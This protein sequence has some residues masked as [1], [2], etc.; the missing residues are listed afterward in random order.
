MLE[1]RSVLATLKSSL[2]HRG[3]FGTFRR[4]AA[5]P[6]YRFRDWQFD[7]KH[8]VRTAG[9]IAPED[10]DIDDIHKQSAVQYQPVRLHA[11]RRIMTMLAID[12]QEFTF[13]DFGCGKGRA[14]L[15]ASE[16]PFRRILGVE[17]S[18]ALCQAA[19]ENIRA[20]T[21]PTQQC[22]RLEVAC[23]DAAQYRVP[24]EPAVLFFYNPFDAQIMS[25]VLHNLEESLREAPRPLYLVLYNPVLDGLVKKT[26]W[27]RVYRATGQF[28]IYESVPWGAPKRRAEVSQSAIDPVT[29][30]S[31]QGQR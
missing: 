7:R 28:S 17:L 19:R 21:S 4:I 22:K 16:F 10:L 6:L 18:P 27:L 24:R 2:L 15:L 8:N 29:D 23:A 13:V 1:I 9:F 14:M 11:F 5:D 31:R 25:P 26:A 20:Y 12:H 30:P 3:V